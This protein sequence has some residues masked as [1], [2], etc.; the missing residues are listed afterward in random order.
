MM[1]SSATSGGRILASLQA[2]FLAS[3]RA[4]SEHATTTDRVQ[5]FLVHPRLIKSRDKES[6][7]TRNKTDKYPPLSFV[8]R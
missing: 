7:K 1:N 6:M 8:R 4:M 2:V 5:D 3:N